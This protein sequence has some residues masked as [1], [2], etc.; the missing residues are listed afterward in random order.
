M[1]KRLFGKHNE[2]VLRSWVFLACI[3]LLVVLVRARLLDF[4]LERDEG[5]YAYMGQLILQGIP[6]YSEAYNMKFPGTY[7]MYAVIMYLFGQDI[8]GVHLGL[9]IV[10]CAAIFLVFLLARK[11][12]SDIASLAASA[13]Y[14]L[15]SLSY[16]V[17]GFAGHATH[18]VILP[19]LGGILTMLLALKNSKLYTFFFSGLLFGLSFLMK[20]SGIFFFLFG[21]AYIIYVHFSATSERSMKKLIGNL[22]IFSIGGLVPLIFTIA[23]LYFAGAFDKFWYWTF[24]YASKYGSQIPVSQAFDIFKANF[25]EVAGGF[26]FLWIMA[27]AGSIVMFFEQRLRGQRA[28]IALFSLFSFLTVCPG[29]YF[30]LHYFVTLLPA[31]SILTGIFVQWLHDRSVALFK[32]QHVGFIGI[33]VFVLAA[34]EGM[35]SQKGYLFREDPARLSRFIYN[36]NPFPESIE[37]AKFIESQ[38]DVT[39][40]IAVFGSEPQI[41]FYSKRHSATGYLYVY[42]LMEIHDYSLNMQQE[43]I[44]EVMSSQPKFII[45]VPIATSWLMRPDSEKYIFRWLNDYVRNNY[46]LVG[47]ADIISS[48][49]TIYRWYADAAQYVVQSPNH[50]LVF[51][52]KYAENTYYQRLLQK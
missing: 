27:A 47:V 46:T 28:F 5:E 23:Y 17:L 24:E 30:R 36:V 34:G 21:F 7:F 39:D 26:T 45:V 50:V 8:Q 16:S 35:V 51:E 38:S 31:I 20:Q 6:P 13:S 29:F 49:T 48:E 25:S 42:S 44:H 18:F 32:M 33:L 2:H 15:L 3:I 40:H 52:R 4:P 43:M 1:I 37:I 19:A 14:A 12:V 9:M 10:N 11:L 41:Y 22:S